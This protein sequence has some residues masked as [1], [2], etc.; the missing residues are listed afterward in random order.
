MPGP[1]SYNHVAFQGGGPCR[2]PQ[3]QLQS[4][5]RHILLG[6]L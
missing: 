3:Q 6:T 4:N 5:H 2:V 1:V